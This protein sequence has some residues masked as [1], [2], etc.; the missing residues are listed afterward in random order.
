MMSLIAAVSRN[1]VIGSGLAIPWMGRLRGDMA[2]FKATTTGH[3]VVMGRKTFESMGKRALPNRDNYVVTRQDGYDAPGATVAHSLDE[4]LRLIGDADLF[5]IG[6]AELYRQAIPLA[7]RM[8]LT[9]VDADVEG[10]VLFPDYD[11]AEWTLISSEPHV[12]DEKNEYDYVIET[13]ERKH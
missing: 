13:Y 5:V 2:F 11:K 6:G 8:H 4:A 12:K 3:P 9:R 7:D 1:G 10:D